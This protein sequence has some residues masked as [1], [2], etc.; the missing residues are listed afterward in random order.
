MAMKKKSVVPPQ[1]KN[2]TP[3]SAKGIKAGK[4]RSGGKKRKADI[5]IGGKDGMYW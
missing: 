5:N 2:L 3:P 1:N 4:K